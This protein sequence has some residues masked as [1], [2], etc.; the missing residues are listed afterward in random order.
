M[1]NVLNTLFITRNTMVLCITAMFRVFEVYRLDNYRTKLKTCSNAIKINKFIQ[2][3][4]H[5]NDKTHIFT[6]SII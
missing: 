2:K 5:K 1:L 4:G 6:L 3:K